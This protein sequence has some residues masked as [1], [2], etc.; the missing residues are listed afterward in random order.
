MGDFP[1]RFFFLASWQIT[2]PTRSL[3]RY[4]KYGNVL[5]LSV[6]L[7]CVQRY[8][9]SQW[10]QSKQAFKKATQSFF[11]ANVINQL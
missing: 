6:S 11:G 8:V 9:K 2:H 3:I 10:L 1:F 7:V 5:S 4:V